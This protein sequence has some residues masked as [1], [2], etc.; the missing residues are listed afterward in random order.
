MKFKFLNYLIN[1]MV[2]MIPQDVLPKNSVA[3]TIKKNYQAGMRPIDIALLLKIPKQVVNYWIHHPI[4][5]KRKRRTKLTRKEKDL[6]IKWAKDRPINLA[7]ARKIQ[8]KFNSLSK[9][10]KEKTRKKKV[11]LSTVNRTLNSFLSRPKQIK[12]VFFLSMTNREQRLKF[13][14]FMKK[15]RIEPD[16]IFFTDEST[17][18]LSSYFNRNYKIRLSP[19]TQK[20]INRGDELALKKNYS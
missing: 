4:I 19:Q 20:K 7:S 11:S 3:I 10:K 16:S 1:L 15:N 2:K 8:R 14:K 13:L 18:N 12:K 9:K 17:F 5:E 6:M